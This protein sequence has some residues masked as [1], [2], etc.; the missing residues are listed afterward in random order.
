MATTT[1]A[2]HEPMGN[3]AAELT[4]GRALRYAW[5]GYLVLL[6]CPFL[7]FLYAIW[8][9]QHDG[10]ARNIVLSDRWFITAVAYMVIVVP[11]S[12]FVRSRFFLGYWRGDCV[13]PRDYLKGMYT[14]WITLE[15]GGLLSLIGCLLSRS[16]LPSL[17]PALAAFMMFVVLW[18]NGRAMICKGRGASDDPE[19]YEEPR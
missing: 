5:Y 3:R 13:A 1:I 11:I 7:L 16:L 6:A 10:L 12:F 19:R 8:D 18:P 2:T 17:L 4:P 14:V 15:A 9:L